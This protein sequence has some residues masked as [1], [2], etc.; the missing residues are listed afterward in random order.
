MDIRLHTDFLNH[1]KTVKLKKRLGADGVLSLISL[2]LWC[3]GAKPDG[4][5]DG[6][7][8]E[9]IE[10]A[11]GWTG[12]NG[13]FFA[14][15]VSLAWIDETETGYTLHAWTERNPWAAGAGHRSD[16]ARMSALAQKYPKIYAEYARAGK[17]A[18]TK[19]EYQA[20]VERWEAM[21]TAD[22]K[23]I[24]SDS[25]ANVSE[26]PA[27]R[28]KFPAPSPAPSPY[29]I[30]NTDLDKANKELKSQSYP[31]LSDVAKDC[32]LPLE[33][34][35]D[36]QDRY[37]SIDLTSEYPVIKSWV[38][39]KGIIVKDWKAYLIKW[40]VKKCKK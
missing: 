7:D 5:L 40:L 26:S 4:K 23:D 38:R 28:S 34:L 12:E 33:V 39:K 15:L 25:Q 1:P 16:K 19:E 20:A 9:D 8:V 32:R 2:W 14:E 18:I 21:T 27:F 10:I 31:H 37:I 24:M 30:Q 36:I 13:K 3:A 17:T 35:Q 29:P 22:I 6:L 11:A